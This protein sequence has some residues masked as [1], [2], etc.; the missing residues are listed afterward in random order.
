MG[1]KSNENLSKFLEQ[2]SLN[3]S[4]NLSKTV[5]LSRNEISSDSFT[6]G[7]KAADQSIN[8]VG[9]QEYAKSLLQ[10]HSFCI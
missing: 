10:K 4:G 1:K 5:A 7:A 6:R 9:E 3:L 8:T 2:R